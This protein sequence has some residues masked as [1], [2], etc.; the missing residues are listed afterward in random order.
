MALTRS[1]L[2]LCCMICTLGAHTAI[3]APHSCV[4]AGPGDGSGSDAQP[5]LPLHMFG[6][7]RMYSAEQ[8]CS[9]VEAG[10][11]E[12]LQHDACGRWRRRRRG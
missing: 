12:P 9:C 8:P 10:T 4:E 2:M 5:F 1:I 6:P 3:L 11:A 7:A